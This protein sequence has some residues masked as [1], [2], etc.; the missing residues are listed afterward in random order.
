MQAKL[1]K[2]FVFTLDQ[3]NISEFFKIENTEFDDA[4]A[5]CSQIVPV[6]SLGLNGNPRQA[7]RFLNTMLIRI[8]MAS[9]K[10]MDLKR[11][12]LAKLMLLEYF[13]PETFTDFHDIQA[14]NNG[15]IALL[16]KLENITSSPVASGFL[17]GINGL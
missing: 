1:T 12:V 15:V 13:K 5:L 17:D 4:I 11:R 9:A 16:E 3:T 14:G 8:S 7:K 6:L 10:G 2:G